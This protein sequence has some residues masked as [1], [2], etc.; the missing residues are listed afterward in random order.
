MNLIALYDS[1]S[2]PENDVKVFNAIAVPEYPNFRVA[3]DFE[4]NSILLLSVSKRI[5][6]L[7]LKNFRLKY[8]QLEQNLDCK[9]YENDSFKFQ[10]FTVITFRCSD[11]NLQ[12][13]FIRISESLVKTVGQ[14]PTQQKIID[15]LKKFVEVFKTLTDS[16]TNTV[17]GL[18]SELFL[19]ENS[20]NPK[21][22]INYWHNLPEE[23]FDFNAGKERIE[24][25]SSSSFER[26]HIFSAEQLNPPSDT[27]V[28]IASVF[29]KQHNSGNNIQYLIDR[30]SEKI[31]YDFDTVEKLNIIVFRTLGSSLEYSISVKFDYDIAQ[32]S[33]RF[34]RHQ[35]I[36][37]IEV[38][39]IPN[40]VTEVKY[41]SDL[42]HIKPVLPNLIYEK[43]I[44]FKLL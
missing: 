3:I 25:K 8:L 11:R 1:L 40:N 4:G 33:L 24:V 13:Y 27:Q 23:K 38:F 43:N 42:S 18:W 31:D 14:N 20:T 30:I 35:D 2:L 17:N 39:N 26:K 34:Y 10:T 7:S 41:K 6:D 12:E 5:K 44:L 19:I 21:E 36:D 15:S 32:Q 22:L 9:I 28:L 37:K 16:P 29:L